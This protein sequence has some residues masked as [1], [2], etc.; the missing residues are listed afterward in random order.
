MAG[1]P[2]FLVLIIFLLLL[3]VFESS[4]CGFS[5][6]LI[7]LGL[8]LFFLEPDHDAHATSS[9]V[10]GPYSAPSP[11]SASAWNLSSSSPAVGL[12]AVASGDDGFVKDDDDNDAHNDNAHRHQLPVQPHSSSSASFSF[13]SSSSLSSSPSSSLSSPSSSSFCLNFEAAR[14]LHYA[15]AAFAWFVQLT[16]RGGRFFGVEWP[17][18]LVSDASCPASSGSSC[19]SHPQPSSSAS[20]SFS[21]SS[22]FAHHQQYQFLVSHP[23]FL[24]PPPPPP[25]PLFPLPPSFVHH[26]LSFLSLLHLLISSSSS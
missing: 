24:S 14:L 9:F 18:S 7:V 8:L 19:G 1:F 4:V 23:S 26:W 17:S 5:I 11:A 15:T 2:S 10:S 25:P 20:S 16:M 21:S 12:P 22:L 6:S 13:S 3:L